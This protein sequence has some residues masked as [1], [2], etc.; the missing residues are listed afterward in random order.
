MGPN[1]PWATFML[2]NIGGV[3]YA[4][5][6]YTPTF[7]PNLNQAK[8]QYK[9][10]R[11]FEIYKLNSEFSDDKTPPVA[12]IYNN[13]YT[14]K[15]S[16]FVA[17]YD[18]DNKLNYRPMLGVHLQYNSQDVYVFVSNYPHDAVDIID[19]IV[20][21]A[22]QQICVDLKCDISNNI[23]FLAGVNIDG[24]STTNR[25]PSAASEWTIFDANSS[26]TC[27]ADARWNVAFDLIAS[28][29]ATLSSSTSNVDDY[30]IL[31]NIAEEACNK[32]GGI[33]CGNNNP[34]KTHLPMYTQFTNPEPEPEP[35]PEPRARARARSNTRTRARART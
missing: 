27:C 8:I 22:F 18:P 9:M 7:S 17:M 12:L 20:T 35:T 10:R 19:N 3:V 14:Y 31:Q 32:N 33:T 28:S 29:S 6:T 26:N 24:N 16:S 11:N 30:N 25:L 23:F 2:D 15:N 4:N 13:S 1:G 21:P 5:V 34:N